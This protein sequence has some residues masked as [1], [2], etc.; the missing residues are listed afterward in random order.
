MAARFPTKVQSL[1]ECSLPLGG[2]VAQR[3]R[4]YEWR[5][6]KSVKAIAPT[7]AALAFLCFDFFFRFVKGVQPLARCGVGGVQR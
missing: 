4:G 7:G 2:A 5:S 1:G 3:L 6:E